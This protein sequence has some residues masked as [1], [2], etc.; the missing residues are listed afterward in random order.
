M[1]HTSMTT[2]KL[3]LMVCFVAAVFCG[4]MLMWY[5]T[6]PEGD[7]MQTIRE[8]KARQLEAEELVAKR[9]EEAEKL[10]TELRA[11]QDKLTAEVEKMQ[12]QAD[13]VDAEYA[14]VSEKKD[15][16]SNLPEEVLAVRKSYGEKIRQ[17][18]DKIFAGEVD[19]KIC[20]LTF[21]DGPSDM[22][23]EI[24]AKLAEHEAY[25]TFFTIGTSFTED[26]TEKMRAAMAGGHTVGNHSNTHA[27][28]WGLYIDLESLTSQIVRQ[29]ENVYKAT[30]FHTDIFRFPNG[31]AQ[32]PIAEDAALWLEEHG[33]KWVDWNVDAGDYMFWVNCDQIVQN[34]R[35]N[36]KDMPI[37][38]VQCHETN[39][40]ICD[41]LDIIIPELKEQ[42]YIFLPLLPQSVMMGETTPAA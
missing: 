3:L 13:A 33:Y 31:S 20:Y 23:D 6:F 22:T 4:A 1:N 38:V 26:K 28:E 37:A 27:V 8:T 36:S 25:A 10:L 42:G 24:I 35:E 12:A 34:I 17:L 16:L 14:A 2:T 11:E 5:V 9:G 18:E 29:D 21:E 7:Y 15:R 32:C 30:G 39:G 19:A 41:A 40:A